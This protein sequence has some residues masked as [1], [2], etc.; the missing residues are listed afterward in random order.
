VGDRRN[1]DPVYVQRL[2]TSVSRELEHRAASLVASVDWRS[3]FGHVALVTYGIQQAPG[4][5]HRALVPLS[6]PKCDYDTL[7]TM[8]RG[9]NSD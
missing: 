3:G 9:T 5:R 7:G 8:Q 4:V 6:G 1:G 2:E